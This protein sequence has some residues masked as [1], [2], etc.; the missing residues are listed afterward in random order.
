MTDAVNQ[1]I[2]PGDLI[3]TNFSTKIITGIVK[4]TL[5]QSTIIGLFPVF[6]IE[7]NIPRISNAKLLTKRYH[8][9]RIIK[10]PRDA[11]LSCPA[12][13]SPNWRSYNVPQED[14]QRAAIRNREIFEWLFQVYPLPK[15]KLPPALKNL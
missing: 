6:K 15:L 5:D 9:S 2:F 8:S 10:V 1:E 13:Y 14:K 3:V 4:Q 11:F 12:V 7:R